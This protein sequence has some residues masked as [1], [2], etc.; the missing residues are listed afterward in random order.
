MAYAAEA[1]DD[2]RLAM[3]VL[4]V[5]AAWDATCDTVHS[6]LADP[7][8]A[9]CAHLTEVT[10]EAGHEVMLERPDEVSEALETWL[11]SRFDS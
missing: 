3:P 8:R 7:M 5:H 9:S 2:G 1:P 4:F 10:I 6:R 11:T